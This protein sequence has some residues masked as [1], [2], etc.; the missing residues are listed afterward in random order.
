MKHWWLVPVPLL[1]A[2]AVVCAD[3]R[4]SRLQSERVRQVQ[5]DRELIEE[6]VNL[7]LRLADDED[8]LKRADH[9]SGAA[10]RFAREIRAAATNRE[11]S[12]ALE[13][14][15][16]LN[17][18]LQRGVADNLRTAREQ[19]PVGSAE[20]QTLREVQHHTGEVVLPLQDQLREL[21]KS[22]KSRDL[23]DTLSTIG[24]AW[25]VVEKATRPREPAP[26]R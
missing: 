7:G 18:L 17:D 5:R 9:C 19:I 21:R 11:D 16:H 12:R 4:A 3:D 2:V 13:M 23:Q 15:R 14:G 25:S 20:E 8:A 24:A 26:G 10:E 6:L 1:V 22:D